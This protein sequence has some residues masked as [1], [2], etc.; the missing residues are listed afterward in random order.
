MKIKLDKLNKISNR[1]GKIIKILSKN[2]RNFKKFGEVY[3]SHVKYNSI[4]AWKKHSVAN[5]NLTVIKGKVRFVFYDQK[6]NNFKSI[7]LSEKINKIIF[8]PK[9]CWFGFK[10]LSKSENVILSLSSHLSSKREIIRKNLKE[11]NFNWK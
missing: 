11:I 7:I 5:I 10:G 8:I 9:K 4:K 2:S 6:N 1:K 3:L